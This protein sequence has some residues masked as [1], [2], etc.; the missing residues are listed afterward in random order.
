MW[1][2]SMVAMV[3]NDNEG[4]ANGHPVHT[5]PK[6][7]Q[8]SKI[9]NAVFDLIPSYLMLTIMFEPKNM[10]TSFFRAQNLTM[11]RGGF[12]PDVY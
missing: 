8:K 1:S 3:P 11:S 9:Q 10:D 6:G 4:P 5:A 7:G 2:K 12:H